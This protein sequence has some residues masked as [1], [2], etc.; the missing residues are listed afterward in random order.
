MTH[1]K[2]Y[3]EKRIKAVDIR[4]VFM[5]SFSVSNYTCFAKETTLDLRCHPDIK[6]YHTELLPNGD[7]DYD[8]VKVAP[9]CL[10][11]GANASG[12]SRFLDALYAM[13]NTIVH[14]SYDLED[15]YCRPDL[16]FY[17]DQNYHRKP[18]KFSINLSIK[19]V[20]YEYGF[21]LHYNNKTNRY[22][23]EREWLLVDDDELKSINDPSQVLRF[24]R[25]RKSEKFFLSEMSDMD[26]ELYKQIERQVEFSSGTRLLLHFLKE[27]EVAGKIIRWFKSFSHMDSVYSK[28]EFHDF[29]SSDDTGSVKV[30]QELIDFVAKIDTGIK[31]IVYNE[32]SDGSNDGLVSTKRSLYKDGIKPEDALTP[33]SW[34]SK[35]TKYLLGNI[36]P[37]VF[38]VLETGGLLIIDEID[39]HLHPYVAISLIKKFH[40]ENSNNAQLIFSSHNTFFMSKQFLRAEEVCFTEKEDTGISRLVSLYDYYSDPKEAYKRENWGIDYLQEMYTMQ[41]DM[42]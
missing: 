8:G 4:D 2:Y 9:I 5:V 23:F 12:K 19:N 29:F 38:K 36:A 21:E 35:G 16:Y 3:R 41:P 1:R 14:P 27:I 34:E 11:S 28:L 15:L 25:K 17:F 31:D 26:S 7:V 20:C 42:A 39:S 37:R 13:C 22:E 32:P 6:H 40:F 24:E 18:I 10:I 30:K 33:L